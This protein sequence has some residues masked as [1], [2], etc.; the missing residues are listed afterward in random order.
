VP[1]DELAQDPLQLAWGADIFK[2]QPEE[3]RGIPVD[4]NTSPLILP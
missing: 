4:N 2:A 3:G 1:L